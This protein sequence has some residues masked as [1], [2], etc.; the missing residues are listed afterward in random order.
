MFSHPPP[1]HPLFLIQTYFS[2][3]VLHLSKMPP[4]MMKML[5]HVHKQSFLLIPS[6]SLSS[7]YQIDFVLEIESRSDRIGP[8]SGALVVC[9][10]FL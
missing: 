8:L 10:L 3:E 2:S 6:T 5:F 1:R 9:L 4:E 7:L